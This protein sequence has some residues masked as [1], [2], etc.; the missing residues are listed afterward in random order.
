MLSVPSKSSNWF[1]TP[2]IVPQESVKKIQYKIFDNLHFLLE[3][4]PIETVKN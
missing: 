2:K 3:W 4:T 1:E